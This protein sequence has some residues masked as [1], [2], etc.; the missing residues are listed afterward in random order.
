V[1]KRSRPG[2][3]ARPS[4]GGLFFNLRPANPDPVRDGFLIPFTSPTGGPLATPTEAAQDT[5]DVPGVIAHLA[6]LPNHPRHA[7]Q[8]PQVGGK[9][10]AGGA[11]EQGCL[12]SLTCLRRQTRLAASSPRA[13]Q[14]LT[15]V[16]TPSSVPA[17]GRGA[18]D[19]KT[20]NNFCLRVALSKQPGGFPATGFQGRKVPPGPKRRIH[21]PHTSTIRRTTVTLFC[22][23]H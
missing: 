3:P 16:P 9:P 6:K 15:A 13:F 22:E 11:F 14:T 1:K 8:G 19:L 7:L 18:T 17:M 4:T 2:T 5:P 10:P 23:S 12:Q 20:P 21:G